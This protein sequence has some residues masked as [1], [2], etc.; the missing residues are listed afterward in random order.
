[1]D[2][3]HIPYPGLMPGVC[4]GGCAYVDKVHSG[5]DSWSFDQSLAFFRECLAIEDELAIK[6]VHETHRQRVLFNPW[7][8]RDLLTALPGLKVNA[9]LSHFCV[10]AER[11]FDDGTHGEK[12]VFPFLLFSSSVFCLFLSSISF[13]LP[14]YFLSL[15]FCSIFLFFRSLFLSIFLLLLSFSL[16]LFLIIILFS[17]LFARTCT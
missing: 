1:M 4:L 12:D 16:L 5:C 14:F 8:T 9:D 3:R 11:I 2:T 7:V 10:V 13:N 15:S 6:V 17:A